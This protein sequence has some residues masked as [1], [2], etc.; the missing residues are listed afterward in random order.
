M[1]VLTHF[2]KKRHKY[3]FTMVKKGLSYFGTLLLLPVSK[4]NKLSDF[5]S[6]QTT[7]KQGDKFKKVLKT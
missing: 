2:D 6:W 1:Y 4:I 3:T 5:G 7:N